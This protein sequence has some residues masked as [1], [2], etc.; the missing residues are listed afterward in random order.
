MLLCVAPEPPTSLRGTQL[1]PTTFDFA[2]AAPTVTNG[3]ITGYQLICQPKV[4]GI[5]VPPVVEINSGATISATLTNLE[6]S[7]TYSCTVKA[8]NA[9]GFSLPSVAIEITT[10]TEGTGI[11]YNKLYHS[12]LQMT[13]ECACI[14]LQLLV[15]R[16]IRLKQSSWPRC[17]VGHYW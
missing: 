16:W 2:W 6:N 13:N 9:A 1:G 3:G 17:L 12:C 7:A 10:T 14:Y 5:V 4:Y 11:F 15:H 8:R